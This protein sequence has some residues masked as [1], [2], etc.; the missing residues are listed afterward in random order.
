M[1][2][3]ERTSGNEKVGHLPPAGQVDDLNL[4]TPLSSMNVTPD[5]QEVNHNKMDAPFGFCFFKFW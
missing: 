1:R 3:V 5:E 2:A 4:I